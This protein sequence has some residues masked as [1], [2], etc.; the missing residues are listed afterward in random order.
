LRSENEET[1]R[2][3]QK[4]EEYISGGILQYSVCN[5]CYNTLLKTF[6]TASKALETERDKYLLGLK[7][8]ESEIQNNK[9]TYSEAGKE[10]DN[11]SR[12]V[13]EQLVE[14]T[15]I[16][17]KD[18]LRKIPRA[19][20]ETIKELFEELKTLEEE[21]KLLDDDAKDLEEREKQLDEHEYW[22]T[23]NEYEYTLMTHEEDTA[24][25]KN[26]WRSIVKH[27][28]YLKELNVLNDVFRIE[29]DGEFGTISGFRLG[30]LGSKGNNVEGDEIN[31]AMG[32]CVLL[33]STIAIK[34]EYVFSNIELKPMG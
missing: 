4:A 17:D 26:Q 11:L 16:R 20:L 10:I 32:Q 6:E 23:E 7:Q 24:Q 2:R 13:Y 1:K 25:M 9:N 21:E 22:K 29:I 27:Y 5:A 3:K 33:L 30:T 15:G 28:D 18:T 14:E 8:L 19:Q 34:A 12:E 31:A